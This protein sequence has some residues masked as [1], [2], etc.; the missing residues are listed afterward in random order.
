VLAIGQLLAVDEI[1][2]GGPKLAFNLQEVVELGLPIESS[3]FRV[4]GG[5][6]GQRVAV[7]ALS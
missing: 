6:D 4:F 1:R 3:A 5:A 2:E 7:T